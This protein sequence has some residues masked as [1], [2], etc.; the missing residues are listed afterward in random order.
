MNDDTSVD[1]KRD[2]FNAKVDLLLDACAKGTWDEY[3]PGEHTWYFASKDK[4][5]QAQVLWDRR[6]VVFRRSSGSW[7][8]SS[9]V[10]SRTARSG[11]LGFRCARNIVG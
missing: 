4:R 8:T 11:N 6:I 10:N 3:C 2:E 5:Y 9:L 1:T 7:R